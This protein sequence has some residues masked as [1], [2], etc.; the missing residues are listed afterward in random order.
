[1]AAGFGESL[2]IPPLVARPAQSRSTARLLYAAGTGSQ[3]GLFV[4]V[5]HKKVAT[6]L[7]TLAETRSE[8]A[9]QFRHPFCGFLGERRGEWKSS[10]SARVRQRRGPQI[11]SP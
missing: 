8:V 3:H 11:G 5:R 9:S 1:P 4:G 6:S 10:E 2:A 7:R